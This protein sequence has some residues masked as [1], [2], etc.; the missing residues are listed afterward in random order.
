VERDAALQHGD[1]LWSRL[2]AALDACPEVPI[3]TDTDWTGRD[4]FA[5]F[6]RWQ[7]LTMEGLQ[8]VL[9]GG[10]PA[11]AEADED[12]LNARWRAEDSPLPFDVARARC[13]ATREELRGM[14]AKL[15]S[16]Q[17]ASFGHL[18]APDING[19]HYEHHIAMCAPE[20]VA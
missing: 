7:Q 1:A 15:S 14:L 16:A 18:F 8:A 20:L 3:G 19:E 4:V 2:R 17:W 5:H 6:A 11:K 12:T 9:Q 10:K 13:I